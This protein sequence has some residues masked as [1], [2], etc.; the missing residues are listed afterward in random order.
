M[1]QNALIRG[2]QHVGDHALKIV[3]RMGAVMIF[4]G[5][6]LVHSANSFRRLA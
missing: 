5:L 2:L 1:A 6:I 3:E 4:L